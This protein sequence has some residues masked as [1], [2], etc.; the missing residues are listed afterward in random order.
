[1]YNSYLTK[2]RLFITSFYCSNKSFYF[3]QGT[4][5]TQTAAQHN[6]PSRVACR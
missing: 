1:M 2:K 4:S 6:A 5:R 3:L